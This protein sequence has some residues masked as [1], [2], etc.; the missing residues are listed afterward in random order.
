MAFDTKDQERIKAFQTLLNQAK[1][2]AGT[3][4]GIWG[5]KTNTAALRFA[6]A[7]DLPYMNYKSIDLAYIKHLTSEVRSDCPPAPKPKKNTTLAG[8]WAFDLSCRN[9]AV[10]GWAQI[11]FNYKQ[12]STNSSWY[13]VNY[14]NN[15]KQNFQGLASN[16]NGS[17]NFSL[18]QT[19]GSYHTKGSGRVS[20]DKRTLQG[21][22]EAGCAFQAR[23]S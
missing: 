11:T 15:L 12:S 14:T 10:K 7:N 3:A 16:N 17:F 5:R 6:K 18:N 21:L 2:V 22:T 23:R 19:N 4:D 1:C 13:R 9:G 20:A 8:R